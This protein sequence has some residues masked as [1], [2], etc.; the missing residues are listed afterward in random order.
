M[1]HDRHPVGRQ[2]DV[3]LDRV[4]PGCDRTLERLERVL[5]CLPGCSAVRHDEATALLTERPF[6][7]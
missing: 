6:R 2:P 7:H 5:G 1:H 4:G 3:E